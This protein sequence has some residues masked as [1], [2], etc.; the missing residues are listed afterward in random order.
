MDKTVLILEDDPANLRIFSEILIDKGLNVLEAMTSEEALDA[1]Q[2]NDPKIDLLVSDVGLRGDR[3]SGTDVSVLMSLC[4]KQLPILF[5]T[6]TTVE[7]WDERD[8]HNLRL[9]RPANVKVL[10]KPFVPAVFE[11]A[12]EALLNLSAGSRVAARLAV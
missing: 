6:G 12:V 3:L 7:H 9:L 1:A 11:N 10:G 5:V 8:R 4:R 2:R